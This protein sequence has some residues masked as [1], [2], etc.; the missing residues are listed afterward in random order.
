[1][2]LFRVTNNPCHNRMVVFHPHR[3]I[4]VS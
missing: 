3:Y 4:L 2:H 1:M